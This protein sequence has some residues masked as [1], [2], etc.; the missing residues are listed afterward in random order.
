[1]LSWFT[2]PAGVTYVLGRLW[3]DE[4]RYDDACSVMEALA[5]SFGEPIASFS[6][7]LVIRSWSCSLR[8]C[9]GPHSA[10]SSDDRDALRAVLP[11]GKL[12]ET[13]FGFYLHA[14]ELLNAALSTYHDVLF[15]QLA[16]SNAPPCGYDAI[17]EQ[18]DQVAGRSKL[19]RGRVHGSHIRP[20]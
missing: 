8:H 17:V 11:A 16:L 10:L 19:V 5:G 9:P 1:M 15:T 14:S 13:R 18:R 6:P 4:G 2:R 12:F 7:V 20:V 3:L